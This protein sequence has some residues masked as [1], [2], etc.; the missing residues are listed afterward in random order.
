MEGQLIEKM[1]EFDLNRITNNTGEQVSN[2]VSGLS[3]RC[4]FSDHKDIVTAI[5]CV[6]R[7]SQQWMVSFWIVLIYRLLLDGIKEFAYMT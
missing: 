5:Q 2:R 6:S 4:S 1:N 3:L 7:D